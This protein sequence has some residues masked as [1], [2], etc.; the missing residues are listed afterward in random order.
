MKICPRLNHNEVHFLSAK[1]TLDYLMIA[2]YV[3]YSLMTT[4]SGMDTWIFLYVSETE[5]ETETSLFDVTWPFTDAFYTYNI[6]LHGHR[7][8]GSS[9]GFT[10]EQLEH[11]DLPYMQRSSTNSL[12]DTL[13]IFSWLITFDLIDLFSIS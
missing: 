12:S 4:E 2:K 1:Y 8:V 9:K 11:H 7:Q 6:I 5:R 3:Y 10:Q 13:L